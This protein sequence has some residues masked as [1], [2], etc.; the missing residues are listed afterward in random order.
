L[1]GGGLAASAVQ[2]PVSVGNVVPVPNT[3]F[4]IT[5]KY[6]R[7]TLTTQKPTLAA[8]DSLIVYQF[9][10][11]PRLRELINDVHSSSILCR[12]PANFSFGLWL[13]DSSSTYTLNLLCT[14]GP[15]ANQWT[16][17]T[18]PNIAIWTPSGTFPLTSG[19]VGY[20]WGICLAAG[21]SRTGTSNGVWLNSGGLWFGAVGQSNFA[22][23]PVNTLFDLA[24]VGDEPGAICTTPQDLAFSDNLWACERYWQKTYDYATAV[25]TVINP[26]MVSGGAVGTQVQVRGGVSFRQRMAKEPTV[27]VYSPS[28]TVTA[29]S[30]LQIGGGNVAATATGNVGETGY[31]VNLSAAPAASANYQWHHVADTGW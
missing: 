18:L 27:T 2:I 1:G 8:T 5:S 10:E 12:G 16:M 19:S 20:L 28:A 7:V 6:L 17:I 14:L 3:N 30:V 31:A 13:R 24:Y 25:A 9:V 26:G 22:A 15:V 4:G 21:S 23:Q 11:G 29:N